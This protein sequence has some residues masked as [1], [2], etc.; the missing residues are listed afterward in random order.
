MTKTIKCTVLR[1]TGNWNP[2]W[3]GYISNRLRVVI[4]QEGKVLVI[5]QEFTKDYLTEKVIE[6]PWNL[7]TVSYE[8]L[9][10]KFV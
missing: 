7:V 3:I 8:V 9:P 1:I 2:V 10:R 6:I 4:I 5:E